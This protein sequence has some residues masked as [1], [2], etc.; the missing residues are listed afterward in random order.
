MKLISLLAVMTSLT[1]AGVLSAR[2]QKADKGYLAEVE[3]KWPGVRFAIQLLERIQ[4]NRLLVVVR[5]IAT[6]KAERSGTFLGTKPEIPAGTSKEEIASGRYGPKPFSLASTVMTDDQ[7]QR[8]YPVLPS[9]APVGKKYLPSELGI[10]L[11]PGQSETLTIQFA[12]PSAPPPIDEG[13]PARQ[14]VSF[15]LPGAKEPVDGVP[16]PPPVVEQ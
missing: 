6:S 7:T 8:T 2:A 4:D 11:L 14:T 9:V 10:G 16:V 15:L 5:V 13:K 1:L 12:A 3:T